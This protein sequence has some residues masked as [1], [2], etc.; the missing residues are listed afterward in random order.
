MDAL[1]T[2]EDSGNSTLPPPYR[3]DRGVPIEL[4]RFRVLIMGRRNAGKTTILRKMCN[5][6]CEDPV[7]RDKNG[8]VVREMYL[9]QK[10]T[11][12][13]KTI[14]QISPALSALEPTVE[15]RRM[16][17]QAVYILC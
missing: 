13:I 2:P 11:I 8:Q 1:T 10:L 15:V 12:G 4:K 14:N 3:E 7:V 5:N 6:T 9:Y 17:A 16:Q